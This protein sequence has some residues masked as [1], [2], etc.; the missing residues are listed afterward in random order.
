MRIILG[1]HGFGF[2][3]LPTTKDRSKKI[4]R[5]VV[6]EECTKCIKPFH[7]RA[8]NLR[9]SLY[10]DRIAL[11]SE[12]FFLEGNHAIIIGIWSAL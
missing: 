8:G 2:T 6:F 11:E 7:E 3:A 9:L 4:R 5:S 10:R 1:P 12:P